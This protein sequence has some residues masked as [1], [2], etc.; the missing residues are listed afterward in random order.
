MIDYWI[1]V[2]DNIAARSRCGAAPLP[3]PVPAGIDIREAVEFR[4]IEAEIRRMDSDGPTAVDWRK[5]GTLSL[6]I[7]TKQSK[8]IL[9]ACWATYALFRVEGYEGLAI[10]LSILR[11]MVAAHWE[12]LFP[13]LRQ[14]GGRV[15]ALDWL[16]GRLGPGVA[17]IVPTA[18]DASAVVAAYDALDDLARQLSGKLVHQRRALEGLLRALQPYCE[19]ATCELATATEHESTMKNLPSG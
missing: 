11:G 16:V 9:V 5:V 12:G 19:Q 1:M 3:G 14:E 15:G 17:A 2:R 10:G 13:P 8:D 18:A 7:L 6:N 4:W